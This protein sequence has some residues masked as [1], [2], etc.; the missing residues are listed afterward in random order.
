MERFQKSASHTLC[1]ALIELRS[2]R[3]VHHEIKPE[4]WMV[5]KNGTVKFIDFGLAIRIPSD[6]KCTSG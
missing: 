2:Q 6:D 3:I 5:T 4:N 1:Q